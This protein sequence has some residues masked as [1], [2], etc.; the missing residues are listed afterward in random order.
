MVRQGSS[1]VKGYTFTWGVC[2][3]VKE[4]TQK[5]AKMSRGEAWWAEPQNGGIQ[6]RAQAEHTAWF[7]F[8]CLE[9]ESWERHW[10]GIMEPQ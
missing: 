5:L 6:S 7:L 10:K 9:G 1:T 8:W 4:S 2:M 3:L